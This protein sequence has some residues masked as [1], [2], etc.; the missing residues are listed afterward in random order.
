MRCC[1]A[2]AWAVKFLREKLLRNFTAVF[3]Q[4]ND[5]LFVQP[6]IHRGRIVFVAGIMQFFR[7]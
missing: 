4:L 7:Q 2:I 6:H 5:Y 1:R 3:C